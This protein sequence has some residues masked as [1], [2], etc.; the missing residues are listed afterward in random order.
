MVG[1]EVHH[2][3][4]DN[5]P[6]DVLLVVPPVLAESDH[7][8][9]LRVVLEAR[10]RD[11]QPLG[12]RQLS[13][14]LAKAMAERGAGAAIY[15]SRSPDGFAKEIGDWAEGAC[16]RGRFIA[17]TEH[18]VLTAVRFLV[19]QHRLSLIR[20]AN[21]EVNIVGVEAQLARIRT[22]LG[23]VI[24]INGKVTKG[25]DALTEIQAEAD[26]LRNEIRG[27]LVSIEDA[28]RL[29]GTSSA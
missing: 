4:R 21:R 29:S 24:N 5:R 22:A 25:R 23:R 13:E 7:E 12:R 28:L 17:T 11:S 6:G 8:A 19:A 18:N 15:V 9:P 1:A 14:T 26:G 16:D 20:A 27:A 10:D 3:G 2:V